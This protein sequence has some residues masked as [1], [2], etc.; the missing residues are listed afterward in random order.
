MTTS[1]RNENGSGLLPSARLSQPRTGAA[2]GPPGSRVGTRWRSRIASA[3]AVT[4][5]GH[6][7]PAPQ[8]RSISAGRSATAG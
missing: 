4:R 1:P 5:L 3:G 7:A 6:G 2:G 8:S